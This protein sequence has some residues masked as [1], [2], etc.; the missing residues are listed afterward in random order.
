[1]KSLLL[2][3]RIGLPGFAALLV[4]GWA[5]WTHWMVEPALA[6]DIAA[7]RGQVRDAKARAAA[8]VA[9]APK[10]E[11]L[12]REFQARLPDDAASNEMLAA[13][14]KQA[15]AA[16][17]SVE[18]ARFETGATRLPGVVRHRADLP[19]KGRYAAL[20]A[21]LAGAL[22]DNGGLT[23]DALEIE[24]RDVDANDVEAKVTLSL[25]TRITAAGSASRTEG[26]GGR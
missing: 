13:V 4:F 6:D 7:L 5:A 14:L 21:W 9:P 11:V 23:L 8:P 10:T 25:W 18:A 16:G 24:R 12:L 17:L 22:R 19:L 3:R 2:A 15:K 26:D 20:R 1:M